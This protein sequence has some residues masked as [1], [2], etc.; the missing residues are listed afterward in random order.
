MMYVESENRAP[1]PAGVGAVAGGGDCRRRTGGGE[2]V[3]RRGARVGAQA[4]LES[5]VLGSAMGS[6]RRDG[7]RCGREESSEGT[8]TVPCGCDCRAVSSLTSLC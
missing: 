6:W 5:G 2:C 1:A 4:Q 8:D 3:G 7:A